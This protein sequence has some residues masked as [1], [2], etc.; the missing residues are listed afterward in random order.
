M[1]RLVQRIL[2]SPLGPL[3]LVASD[4]AL[5]GIYFPEHRPAP[6]HAGEDAEHPPVL[7]L[8][9]RELD[10]YFAGR[11]R[12][13][14]V[15]LDPRGTE[16]QRA[17]WRALAAIEFGEQRSYA[18]LARQIGQPTAVRA[19]GAANGRNPLSIVLP[20]HRVV[21]SSGALTGY[22]GGLAAKQWLLAHE[23]RLAGA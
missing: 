4:L 20:C 10:E 1:T 2:P 9:A 5:V 8:A 23:Q 7:D 11:R 16:F 17:V 22:A 3:R 19:V 12:R 6:A 21:A 15:A 14:T 18:D 13:F